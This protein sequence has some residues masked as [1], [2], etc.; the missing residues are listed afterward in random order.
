MSYRS[1][2]TGDHSDADLVRHRML[3]GEPRNTNHDGTKA[4]MLAVL[5]EGT[6]CYFGPHGHQRSAAETWIR[7]KDTWAF[8]FI[9]ICEVLDVEPDAVRQALP[10]LKD[11]FAAPHRLRPDA[12][13]GA[14]MTLAVRAR[15]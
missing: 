6:R 9:T 8:S 7:S 15:R 13:L 3:G 12:G 4:L 1:A 11:E 2:R 14:Q 10:R 5:E